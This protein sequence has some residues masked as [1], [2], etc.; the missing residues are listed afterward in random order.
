VFKR[1]CALDEIKALKAVALKSPKFI[2]IRM[3]RMKSSDVNH[4]KYVK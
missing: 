1:R 3:K 2:K 4:V